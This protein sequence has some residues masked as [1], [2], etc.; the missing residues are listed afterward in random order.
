MVTQSTPSTARS[1]LTCWQ[2]STRSADP[3]HLL[4]MGHGDHGAHDD[5]GEGYCRHPPPLI[6]FPYNS[7]SPISRP[8]TPLP[9]N[10]EIPAPYSLSPISRPL[11]PLPMNDVPVPCSPYPSNDPHPTPRLN[12]MRRIFKAYPHLNHTF[13]Y[14]QYAPPNIYI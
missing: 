9:M 1:G 10:A 3:H 12:V 11:T 14:Q 4:L 2:T 8:L 6:Q 7:L 5:D 13:L